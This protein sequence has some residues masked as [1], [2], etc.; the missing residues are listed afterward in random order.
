MMVY[1]DVEL[2][3]N[4]LYGVKVQL[5]E[6]LVPKSRKNFDLHDYFKN[7]Q[8]GYRSTFHENILPYVSLLVHGAYWDSK[9]PRL[10]TNDQFHEM[11]A[12]SRLISV[13]DISC[14]LKAGFNLDLLNSTSLR[15]PWNIWT[16]LL[17]LK[18]RFSFMILSKNNNTKSKLHVVY[19]F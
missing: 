16:T 9:Y 19:I 2:D 18:N 7:G 14:D 17:Q 6:Y 8:Q 15:V 10:L 4:K 5:E 13:A 1:L 3:K 11:S 12:K